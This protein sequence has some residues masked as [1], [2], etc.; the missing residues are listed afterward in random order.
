MKDI[1]EALSK[2]YDLYIASSNK[3]E[4]IASFLKS[5]DINIFKA[6]YAKPTLFGKDKLLLSLL[7]KERLKIEAVLYIGDELRDIE[8]CQK[9]GMDILPVSYGY[10]TLSFLQRHYNQAIMSSP[11]ELYDYLKK[12]AS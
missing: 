5:H 9:I 1:L 12:E 8:S 11:E 3:K 2:S 6:I 10:D 4:L 7:K